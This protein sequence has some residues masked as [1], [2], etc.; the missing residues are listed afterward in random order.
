MKKLLV[1]GGNHIEKDVVTHA[2][3]MGYYVI[4]TDNHEDLKDSPAKQIANEGW[5]I[6]WSDLDTL[7][8][9]CR[10]VGVDGVLA[11][12]SE[13][14]V[15]NMIKLCERLN[16]PCYINLEQL[17]ITRDKL[18]FKQEL[19]KYN[20]PLVPEYDNPQNVTFPV[21]VKPTDRA[22][23][24]G[25]RVA[26]TQ[27]EVTDAINEAKQKSPTGSYIIEKYMAGCTKI[28]A[29]YIIVNDN[30]VFVG[31]NDTLMCPPEKGHEVMQSAWFFPSKKESVYL[32]KV[33]SSFRSFLKGIGVHNGYITLS[34]FID[35]NGDVFVFETGFR[36]SGELSYYYTERKYGVN[37]LDFLI[38]FSLG[39][40]IDKY[41][42]TSDPISEDTCLSINFFGRDGRIKDVILP[43]YAEGDV[44]KNYTIEHE[45]INNHDAIIFKKIAMSMSFGTIDQVLLKSQKICDSISCLDDNNN[46]QIYYKP[47]LQSLKKLTMKKLLVLARSKCVIDYRV[48]ETAKQMGI[49]TYVACYNPNTCM[50]LS[51]ADEY[52]VQDLFD[53]D[54]LKENC[55][56]RG[57]DGVFGAGDIVGSLALELSKELGIRY[58]CNEDSW[59]Y[60]RDKSLFKQKCIE[61]GVPTSKQYFLSDNPSFE[62]LANLDFPV[63]VK[64]IDCTGNVGFGLCNNPTELLDNIDK[65]KKESH[66]GRIL[67]EHFLKGREYTAFYVLA[68]GEAR[69]LNFWA[70]LSQPGTPHNCYTINTTTTDKLNFYLNEVHPN[71][72]KLLKNIGARDGVAWFEFMTDVDGKMY[73]LEMGQRL[74]GDMMYIPLKD[75][76]KFNTI[77]HLINYAVNQYTSTDS[78]PESQSCYWKKGAC[79]YILW[80]AKD[81]VINDIVGIDKVNNIP[82]VQVQQSKEVGD[83]LT[84][85]HYGT[86]VSISYDSVN[87]LCEKIE[88]VNECYHM[89]D[90]YGLDLLFYYNDFD[91]LKLL[92]IAKD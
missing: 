27:D 4:V 34:A 59:R 25:I 72:V 71:V 40:P 41:S 26:Y 30:I 19:Q 14:R 55:I 70:M 67:I 60:A 57:I 8:L 68:N 87:E 32:Q 47:N 56:K 90:E 46:E 38:D 39:N 6:S 3:N 81:G 64:P 51:I 10:D 61:C 89:Y 78:L 37:Y 74:S 54:L 88:M 29:Y 1:L 65:S 12:F 15:E 50:E 53:K 77:G 2:Q 20:V 35:E 5:N 58:Y 23:S 91:T 44:L 52:W 42:I 45:E 33:D 21:I 69:L 36:L 85:Y 75:V 7:E 80:T 79:S 31:S 13:F 24:I 18:K 22:G 9:K 43:Q 76:T 28:D 63:V 92:E 49:Y 11:G 86:I 17:D 83:K 73:A 84:A 48:V 16:L 66:S 82:G 62:E